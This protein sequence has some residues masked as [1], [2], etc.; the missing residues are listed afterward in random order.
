[1]KK[2]YISI[3]LFLSIIFVSG[4]VQ[5]AS[6]NLIASPSSVTV[7]NEFTVSANLSGASIASLSVKIG[8]DTSKVEYVSGPA[9]SSFRNGTA[10]YTWTDPQGG[11]A[12]ITGGTIV[13][14]RFRA[15]AEGTAN[16]SVS[17]SFYDANEQ[18]VSPSF[19]GTSISINPVPTTAPVQPTVNPTPVPTVGTPTNAPIATEAPNNSGQQ[20]PSPTQ[21]TGGNNYQGT[22]SNN[23]NLK[24]MRINVEGITPKF[25]K[26]ITS[27]SVVVSNDVNNINVV[28]VPEDSNASVTIGGN[29]N[30]IEGSNVITISV[31]APDGKTRKNYIINVTKT[32][33][34]ELANASLENL[35]I[36][37][38][39]L[40][41]EFNSE[42]M[43]YTAEVEKEVENLNILAVP[44]RENA[45]VTVNGGQNL[46]FGENVINITVLAEDG[47]TEKIYTVVVNRKGEEAQEAVIDENN[48]N[49]EPKET[50]VIGKIVGV[51]VVLGIA[52]GI[53]YF[54]F[55]K[56]PIKKK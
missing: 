26:N 41:P 4:M 40:N 30:L 18:G 25:S 3:L 51:I 42:I 54:L 56:Y 20:N 11:L 38:V 34:P 52:G 31:T 32:A 35:A 53:G 13:T 37:N 27:Y 8:T 44:Q 28:A 16:F 1:M 48:D 55:S 24:E 17:G 9:S 29:D 43:N 23:A 50:N 7:G 36:E 33:S 22:V 45:K 14:F 19:A 2:T 39:T 6:V 47:L 21:N 15:K 5:G 49:N 10:I 12:P 46:E